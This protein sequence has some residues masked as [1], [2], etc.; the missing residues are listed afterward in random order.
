[1]LYVRKIRQNPSNSIFILSPSHP[2][3]NT[4]V[5]SRV[6][7]T[8]KRFGVYDRYISYFGINPVFDWSYFPIGFNF[9]NSSSAFLD[10]H[11]VFFSHAKLSINCCFSPNFINKKITQL[12]IKN[13]LKF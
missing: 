2:F 5:I 10:H 3:R 6:L 11:P 7:S 8:R 1:M 9:N 12:L 13:H 4:S